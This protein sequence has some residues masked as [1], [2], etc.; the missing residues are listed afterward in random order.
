MGSYSVGKAVVFAGQEW[1]IFKV[2]GARL[3]IK[4]GGLQIW[5]H[6]DLVVTLQAES[7]Y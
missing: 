3:Q 5:V 1:R 6:R 7:Q 4:R 2:E